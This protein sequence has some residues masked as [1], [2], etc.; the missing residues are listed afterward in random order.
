MPASPSSPATFALE[1]HLLHG[2]A[3]ASRLAILHSLLAEERRVSE[4]VEETGLSQPNVSKH[5]ACLWGCGLV[6][7]EKRGRE[8]HYR[9]IDGVEALFGAIN[10]VLERTGETVGS[11]RLTA[12]ALGSPA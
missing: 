9:A 10:G 6:A 4:V 7:R 8:V 2:L 3:D 1:R 5:L 11:C 12:E